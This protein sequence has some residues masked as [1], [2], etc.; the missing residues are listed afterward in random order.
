MVEICKLAELCFGGCFYHW[1]TSVLRLSSS[2]E[3]L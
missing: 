2:S 1:K 3:S